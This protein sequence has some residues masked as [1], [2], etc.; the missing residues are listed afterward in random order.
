MKIVFRYNWSVEWVASGIDT[1]AV[2]YESIDKLMFDALELI[3]E[4]KKTCEQPEYYRNGH[5][6][7]LD[8]EF[9]VGD[10]EDSIH[11]SNF[12]TLEQWFEKHK[13]KL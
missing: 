9:N 13:I 10:L 1:I 12:F 8:R 11:E 2:E 7:F 3:K 5:I 4:Y 6:K